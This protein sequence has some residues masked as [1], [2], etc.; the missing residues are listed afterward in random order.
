MGQLVKSA[1]VSENFG[2]D[3]AFTVNVLDLG[4]M[5]LPLNQV[6]RYMLCSINM[7]S[8]IQENFILCDFYSMNSLPI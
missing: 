2:A 5:Q 1:L 7:N 4:G 8:H 3:S 6:H